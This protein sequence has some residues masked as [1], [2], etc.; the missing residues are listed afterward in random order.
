G[1]A[2]TGKGPGLGVGVPNEQIVEPSPDPLMPETTPRPSVYKAGQK[3]VDVSD[4]T[5]TLDDIAGDGWINLAEST[6]DIA[7][8]GVV[9]GSAQ[10]GDTVTLTI[11]DN[12]YAVTVFDDSTFSLDLPSS[13]L[14]NAPELVVDASITTVGAE[15]PG[16]D[17]KTYFVDVE[18]PDALTVTLDN[19]TGLSS[20]DTITNDSSVSLSGIELGATQEFSLDGADGSWSVTTP[21]IAEGY[22]EFYIRQV[23][24]AGNESPG[25][26]FS[27]TLDST[28]PDITIDGAISTDTGSD[29]TDRHTYDT[30]ID[31]SGTA[32]DGNLEKVELFDG[33]TFLGE[34]TV[35]VDGTWSFTTGVLAEGTHNFTAKAV[36][37]AGNSTITATLDAT[38]DTTAPTV[39]ITDDE[40][41]IGNIAGGDITYTFTF[42]EDVTGFTVD[43]IDITNGTKGTF[44]QAS[45]SEYTLVVTPDAGFEGDVTVAVNAGAAFDVVDNPNDA[46]LQNVQTVDLKAPT[47]TSFTN[48][49][50]DG[51]VS[52]ADNVVTYSV[53]FDE[54]VAA[55]TAAD[56]TITGGSLANG[57]TLAVDGLSA[58]FGVTVDDNSTADLSVTVN[59]TYTDLAGNVGSGDNVTMAVDTVNPTV[60]GFTSDNLDGVV[61]DA[62]NVVAYSVT[63]DEEVAAFTAADLTITGGSLTNGPTLAGDGLSAIFE[64]TVDDNSTAD[65]SV[66]IND[67]VLDLNGNSLV[68]ANNILPVDTENPTAILSHNHLDGTVSDADNVVTYSVTFDEEVAA[69]MAADLTITGGSLTNGPTL[70]GDGLSAS[71]EVTADDGSTVDLSVT[72]NDTVLDLNG[73]TLVPVNN[74]LT[75]DTGN[76]TVD[77]VTATPLVVSDSEAGAGTFNIA[78]TFSE[79]MDTAVAP[80]LTFDADVS[81]SLSLT[82][83]SWD[84]TGTIFTA[85]YNVTDANEEIPDI[86]VDVTGA[87]D[88]SGNIQQNYTDEIE[89]SIETLNPTVLI[90]DDEVGTGNIVG[91]DITYTFTFS[92]IVTDFTVNDIDVTNGTKGA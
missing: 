45:A 7:I 80:I 9:G 23:D 8:T 1:T 37:L 35:A 60:T 47:V 46:A 84:I 67:T 34:A 59:G 40:G 70:A 52:D 49:N 33:G 78:V 79:A 6:N 30:T 65:L 41:S 75:V 4:P 90:T 39:T 19:D 53:T 88:G 87:Q 74:T 14:T 51:V 43:D 29:N 56:L 92:E 71:F 42:S 69:F 57:P 12:V 54:E 61:S 58:I 10:A 68:S 11:G 31:L 36:D 17:A 63:F 5:V 50:L 24:A 77:D 13:I 44:S 89:F 82:G 26:L 2:L 38:I 3:V 18:T 28:D 66:T 62:D 16:L 22:N 85:S 25:S 32:A 55:F 81:A 20:T 27:F 76:P 15:N 73:N 83:G 86:L 72:I 48:D 64:V 21:A 91:G